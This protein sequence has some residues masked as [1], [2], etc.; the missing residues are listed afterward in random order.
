MKSTGTYDSS[1]TPSIHSR[2]LNI[3]S[4]RSPVL[5]FGQRANSSTV[6][7]GFHEVELDDPLVEV[8]F[9]LR[10]V[11]GEYEDK[12]KRKN[13]PYQPKELFR[14]FGGGLDNFC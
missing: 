4:D 11:V 1:F 10:P 12:G 14:R 3:S 2:V 5:D 8:L 9:E 6:S 13:L 7:N